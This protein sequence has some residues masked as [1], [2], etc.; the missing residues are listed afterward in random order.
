MSDYFK[1]VCFKCGIH[2]ETPREYFNKIVECPSCK[3]EFMAVPIPKPVEGLVCPFCKSQS[4]SA[5]VLQFTTGGIILLVLGILTALALVGVLLIVIAF[6]CRE[7]K[8]RCNNCKK[9]F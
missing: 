9:T 7:I 6:R 8:Y 5:G 2:V 1:A 4:V 3:K